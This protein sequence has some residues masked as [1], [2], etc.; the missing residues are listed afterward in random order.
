MKQSWFVLL[1]IPL[2]LTVLCVPLLLRIVP[3]NA[4]YG[5]R[6]PSA[7]ESPENWYHINRLGAGLM[8]GS[9]ALSVIIKIAIVTRYSD[10]TF[11]RYVNIV[12]GLAVTAVAI[13]IL[14]WKK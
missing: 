14:L 7:M 9:L 11:V 12:D 8:I 6:T 2:I 4:W 1:R 5:F 13:I 10:S 3:P